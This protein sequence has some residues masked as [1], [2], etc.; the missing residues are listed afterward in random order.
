MVRKDEKGKGK[1][2]DKDLVLE[3]MKELEKE[4]DMQVRECPKC[5]GFVPPDEDKCHSCGYDMT[6][7]DKGKKDNEV[8]EESKEAEKPSD[9]ETG[10]KED[11]KEES[12]SED[13]RF[14][15]VLEEME[16]LISEED[17]AERE[18]PKEREVSE[19]EVEEEPKKDYGKMISFVVIL[20]GIAT[21]VVTPFVI[22]DSLVAAVAL[23]LGAVIIVIGGN[24]AYSSLQSEMLASEKE[25][26]AKPKDD[27]PEEAS[28]EDAEEEADDEDAE[29]DQSKEE[30]E[31]QK[32]RD[33]EEKSE[34]EEDE[35]QKEGEEEEESESEEPE[36]EPKTEETEP[37]PVAEVDSDEITEADK[38]ILEEMKEEPFFKSDKKN[39]EIEEDSKLDDFASIQVA[40]T[41][42]DADEGK[43]PEMKDD[44]SQLVELVPKKDSREEHSLDT[45][46]CPVCRHSLKAGATECPKCGAL[47]DD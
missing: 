16:E 10:R 22:S 19:P 38:E 18:E 25:L 23:I 24:M 14:A 36:P 26:E 39:E 28:E 41:E 12:K 32:E 42:K 8:E 30:D 33:E 44:D 29:V 9:A 37:E 15:P 34:S 46:K 5:A 21:Y 7:A 6:S 31:S 11:S 27:V 17:E 40:K 3:E 45:Y 43:L 13:D 47:F 2:S 4:L 20:I 35:S 1:E